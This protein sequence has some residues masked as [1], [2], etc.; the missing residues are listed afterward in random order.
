[1]IF[2]QQNYTD[3]V[4]NKLIFRLHISI[5]FYGNIINA[6]E[7]YHVSYHHTFIEEPHIVKFTQ[8]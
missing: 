3:S 2:Y 4:H 6:F 5:P 7:C 8:Q 1:M